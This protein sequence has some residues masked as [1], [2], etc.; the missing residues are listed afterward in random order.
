MD[1]TEL[2]QP[3]GFE[4]DLR[5]DPEAENSAKAELRFF[6]A[7][8]VLCRFLSLYRRPDQISHRF[9]SDE[10]TQ[11]RVSATITPAIFCGRAI[12]RSASAQS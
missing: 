10:F 11:T 7:G 6:G 3:S 4:T 2:G 8:P 5:R 1:V 12:G 9:I